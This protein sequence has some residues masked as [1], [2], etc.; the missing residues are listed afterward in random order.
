M[1]LRDIVDLINDASYD[2]VSVYDTTESDYYHTLYEGIA[3]NCPNELMRREV[4]GL[5]GALVAD[6]Y[7]ICVCLDGYDGMEG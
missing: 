6:N 2:T 4:I 1:I 3:C 5:Y 7:G